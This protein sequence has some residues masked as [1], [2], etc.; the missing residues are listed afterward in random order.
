MSGGDVAASVASV[1]AA[2]AF[3]TAF[4]RLS[5]CAVPAATIAMSA[6]SRRLAYFS[7]RRQW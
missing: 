5:V 2:A 3:F 4:M 6:C 1:A 7:T